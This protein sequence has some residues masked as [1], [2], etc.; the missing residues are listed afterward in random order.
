MYYKDKGAFTGETSQRILKDISC[1]YVIIGHSECRK[2]F[3][4]Q[5]NNNTR[6]KIFYLTSSIIGSILISNIACD[7]IKKMDINRP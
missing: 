6:S 2:Y 7:S 4:K 5:G 3:H 1:A